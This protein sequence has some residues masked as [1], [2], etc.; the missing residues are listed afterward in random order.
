ME[1]KLTLI[2]ISI[3]HQHH[4]ILTLKDLV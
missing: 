1:K 4:G 2:F 3:Y